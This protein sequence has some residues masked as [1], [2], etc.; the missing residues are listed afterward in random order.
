MPANDYG[1]HFTKPL[2]TK[3]TIQLGISHHF[4]EQQD[5][6]NIIIRTAHSCLSF[7]HYLIL[8]DSRN[9]SCFTLVPIIHHMWPSQVTSKCYCAIISKYLAATNS[10]SSHLHTLITC[11]NFILFA[12]TACINWVTPKLPLQHRLGLGSYRLGFGFD[13]LR[14]KEVACTQPFPFVYPV[15]KTINW[16]VTLKTVQYNHST[17]LKNACCHFCPTCQLCNI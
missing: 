13:A 12:W 4:I 16:M 11:N 17:Y 5:S 1:I 3:K 6:A 9:R 14:L 8:W 10:L 7:C 2:K 15:L